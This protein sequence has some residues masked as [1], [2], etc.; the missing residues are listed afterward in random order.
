ML[1]PRWQSKANSSGLSLWDFWVRTFNEAVSST[2]KR[3]R[4]TI[5]RGF[6]FHIHSTSNLALDRLVGHTLNA[7]LPASSDCQKTAFISTPSLKP[8]RGAS[9]SY[10]SQPWAVLSGKHRNFRAR[11]DSHACSHRSRI[12]PPQ[13]SRRFP[14]IAARKRNY[15]ETR[16]RRRASM[17]TSELR[18]QG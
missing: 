8:Q 15:L 17:N 18:K 2:E 1:R 5:E 9:L 14:M 7:R 12:P 11:Q 10:R 16:K 4:Q 3:V 6:L 13:I